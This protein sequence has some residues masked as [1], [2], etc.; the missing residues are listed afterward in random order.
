MTELA[1]ALHAQV[2]GGE[3][4]PPAPVI[5]TDGSFK[6]LVDAMIAPLLAKKDQLLAKRA[7][8]RN[9]VAAIDAEIVT[10]DRMLK[11]A[12]H[13]TAAAGRGRR[14]EKS[15]KPSPA[16]IE[17][18]VRWIAEQPEPV[19]L[20]VVV[21]ALGVGSSSVQKQLKIARNLDLLRNAGH[22]GKTGRAILYAAMP[23]AIA[24]LDAGEVVWP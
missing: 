2:R 9:E 8:L 5:P 21:E 14:G 6:E 18:A 22:G 15:P 10:A 24:R 16:S 13:E 23:D 11:A 17:R 20:L 19:E 3:E 1:D 7:D 4:A 12:G